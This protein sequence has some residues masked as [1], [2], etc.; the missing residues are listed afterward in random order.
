MIPDT[1]SFID[2]NSAFNQLW[3]KRL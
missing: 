1:I 3:M 2:L